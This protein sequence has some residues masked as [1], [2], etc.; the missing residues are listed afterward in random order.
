MNRPLRRSVLL[1]L[2][3]L[4][5]AL[6]APAAAA[7]SRVPEVVVY[8]NPSCGCCGQWVAHMQANGFAVTVREVADPG[9]VRAEQGLADV[10]ASC[11]TALIDGYVLEGHVPAADVKRLLV[12]RPNAVGLAVPGMV[13]G[14]PGMEMGARIDP[15][16]VLLVDRSGQ[17]SVFARYPGA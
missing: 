4:P 8:K 10:F 1:A 16:E 17:S 9:V 12:L 2:A 15:Y 14:S 6:A 5:V 7:R 3:A 11:H 13:V